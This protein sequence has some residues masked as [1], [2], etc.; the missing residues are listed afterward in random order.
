MRAIRALHEGQTARLCGKGHMNA[1]PW[2]CHNCSMPGGTR[3]TVT[4]RSANYLA[5]AVGGPALGRP[6]DITN[7]LAAAFTAIQQRFGAE[8]AW[9]PGEAGT[10]ARPPD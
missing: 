9:P 8:G 4:R 1:T 3:T 7:A 10:P 5:F 2:P 6:R